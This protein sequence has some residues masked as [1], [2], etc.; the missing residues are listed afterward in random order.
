MP[1]YNTETGHFRGIKKWLRFIRVR[2]DPGEVFHCN[3]YDEEK[4]K[5]LYSS[6]KHPL[7][8]IFQGTAFKK[9]VPQLIRSTR[10]RSIKTFFLLGIT[11]SCTHLHPVPSTSTQLISA[12]T[13]LSA[14][15]PT[16]FEP[17]YCT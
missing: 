14:T 12:S 2:R 17:K 7:P 13:Q 6:I 16:I 8:N 4:S 11:N 9:H 1:L 15:P 10:S 5:I 3:G